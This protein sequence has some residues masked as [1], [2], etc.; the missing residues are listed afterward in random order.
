VTSQMFQLVHH[1]M[2]ASA[3]GSMHRSNKAASASA[4]M[5]AFGD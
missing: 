3:V 4:W 1:I 5:D 2:W